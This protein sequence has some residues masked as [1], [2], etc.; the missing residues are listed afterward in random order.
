M[1][2]RP[3]FLTVL[4]LL[5]AAPRMLAQGPANP[6]APV[7]ESN[8]L[9]FLDGDGPTA[10]VTAL[11]FSP[12]GQTLYSAGYDKVV[13][14]WRRGAAAFQP[15]PQATFRVPI[16]PGRDGVINVLAASPD[17]NWL[18]VSGL[19]VFRGGS[20][21]TQPG[22]VVPDDALTAEMRQDRSLIYLFNTQ[23]RAVAL[24]RGHE[25]DVLAL[26]FAP[27]QPGKP[28]LLVSAGRIRGD[29]AAPATGRV[30]VW[31]I[32]KASIL[33]DKN[34]LVDRGARLREWLIPGIVRVPGE[35]PPG[36]AVRFTREGN[37]RLATA[38]GDGKLRILE[39]SPDSRPESVDE[40]RSANG[41]PAEYTH[42]V[43]AIEVPGQRSARL[44][45]GGIANGTG[46]LQA[47]SRP[48]PWPDETRLMARGRV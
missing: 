11:T 39:L 1:S 27:P 14:V 41:R 13:R 25:E 9:P 36:L 12:D 4:I 18:A 24:L 43:V 15:D 20:G 46:Y 26:A 38:W 16:G 23:T 29:R 47:W 48:R 34:E 35:P 40:P 32:A 21:F 42:T 30:C 28:Q 6:A 22:Y 44:L 31:D 8:P 19:G 10:A 33:N 37:P 17:G 7:G 45:T 3:L 5:S 2:V